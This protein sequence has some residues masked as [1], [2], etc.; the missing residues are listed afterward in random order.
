MCGF[1]VSINNKFSSRELDSSLKLLNHRGP[2]NSQSLIINE[3]YFGHTRLAI[4][5]LD[6]RSNQPFQ[7]K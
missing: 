2:D 7:K 4:I 1:L 3:N 6:S 5:D